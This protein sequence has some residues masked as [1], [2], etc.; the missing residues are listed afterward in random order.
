[1]DVEYIA[2]FNEE[3]AAFQ[4][5]HEFKTYTVTFTA[6]NQVVAKVV[7]EAGTTSIEEPAVPAK[8]GYEGAWA[9]Y[10]MA[11]KNFTVKAIYTLIDVPTEPETQKPEDPTEPETAPVTQ[12]ET[13]PE[14]VKTEETTAAPAEETTAAPAESETEKNGSGCSSAIAFT[15]VMLLTAMAAAVALRK[16]N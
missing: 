2:F 5:V 14:T 12:P 6:N 8:E 16:K 9:K 11:D 3:D 7:F 15:G 13:V 4:Y 1:M 10:E